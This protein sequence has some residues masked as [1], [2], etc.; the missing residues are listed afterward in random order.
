MSV[1]ILPDDV[2]LAIFGFYVEE[3]LDETC[4]MKDSEPMRIFDYR[5]NLLRF[6]SS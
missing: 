5:D 1:D 3:A 6:S 4:S 2:L